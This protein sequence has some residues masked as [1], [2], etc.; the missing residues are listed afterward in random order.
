MQKRTELNKKLIAKQ[1][2]DIYLNFDY[3]V[4]DFKDLLHSQLSEVIYI[5]IIYIYM[6]MLYEYMCI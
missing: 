1:T 3:I 6:Y 5:C 4:K 2:M